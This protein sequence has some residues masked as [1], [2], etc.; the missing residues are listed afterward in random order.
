MKKSVQRE[1]KLLATLSNTIDTTSSKF[2]KGHPSIMRLFD[3]IDTPKQL[4]LILENCQ[5][6]IL[7]SVLKKSPEG[8]LTE[9]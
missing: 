1:I 8:K 2:G 9:R 3:A 6:K 4:Y 5:G 7:H